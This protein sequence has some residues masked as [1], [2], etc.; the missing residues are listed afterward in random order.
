MKNRKRG[1]ATAYAA[2]FMLIVTLLVTVL[3]ATACAAAKR[4]SA[5]SDYTD[6]KN[7]LDGVGAAAVACYTGGTE[8]GWTAQY[9]E[10]GYDIITESTDGG[11]EIYVLYGQKIELYMVFTATG[12]GFELT[13]YIYNY[14]YYKYQSEKQ[15]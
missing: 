3:I 6:R 11:V 5:Y 2:V 14:G 7:F 10:S 15:T 4:P 1:F 12:D 13:K 8:S 9:D